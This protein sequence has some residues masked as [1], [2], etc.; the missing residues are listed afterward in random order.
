MEYRFTG[1]LWLSLILLVLM[2]R[3]VQAQ[4]TWKDIQ[5]VEEVCS[6]Y[7]EQMKAMIEAF[8]LDLDD[9]EGVKQAYAV[10]DIPA[11]CNALLAY[12]KN[13]NTSAHLRKEL[14]EVTKKTSS[15]VD[16]VMQDIYT[17]QRVTGQVPRL[18]NGEL[19]W[20]HN[21]PEDDI[22]WAWAMNRHFPVA[23]LLSGYFDT[24]NPKYARQIDLLIKDWIIH[25]WPYPAEKSNTAMWRGL[26]VSFREKVWSRVFFGLINSDYISPATQLLILSSLPEH[27][28]YARNFHGSNNWLTMEMTGLATVATAWPEYK[29]S[30]KWFD[31]TLTQMTESLK[32]QVYPDGTQ[33][34]LT[35][36]YHRVALSNFYLYYTICKQGGISLPAYFTDQIESMWHYLA[37]IMRPDGNALLNNDADLDYNQDRIRKVAEEYD[38]QDWLYIASNGED[39]EKPKSQPSVVFPWAG[40]AISRSGYDRNAHWSFFDIGPWGSGHQHNDMLHLSVSAFGKDFL[41]DAGRFA[42]RGE[43]AKKYRGYAKGSQGHNVVLIDSKGQEPGEKVVNE[44]LSETHFKVTPEFDYAWNSFEDFIDM[45]GESKHTRSLFYVRENFWVVVDQIEID[46]PRKI[47][48]LWHWH[49]RSE[50]QRMKGNAVA[51]M[52]EKGNLKVIPVGKT[53]WNL[54]LIKGQEIPE[55][56]GWYSKQYNQYEPNVA[57]IYSTQIK[58]SQAFVWLLVPFVSSDPEIKAKLISEDANGIRLKI[59]DQGKG[60]WNLDIPFANS[61]NAKL[62]FKE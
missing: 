31:Y 2:G 7:P 60:E 43:V 6:A 25:S 19:K 58:S 42:Y 13:G 45:E 32:E 29:E 46:R 56:Q 41:V 14:P 53:K 37:W 39:G 3:A 34:E 55:I 50:V 11:A 5:T 9:F 54:D 40:H 47:E 18:A 36:H 15:Y 24:G 30:K 1:K 33:T 35:T 28:H 22:E 16:S 26:E 38:H 10:E 59:I 4:A 48:T 12:Y 57:S 62:F 21:G 51:S 49:P 27:A 23:Y 44:P 20:D 61:Q 8:N 52:D 17:F